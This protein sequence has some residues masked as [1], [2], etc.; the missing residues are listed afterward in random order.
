MNKRDLENMK[1]LVSLATKYD[2]LEDGIEKLLED[3]TCK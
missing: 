2:G 3:V 1:E